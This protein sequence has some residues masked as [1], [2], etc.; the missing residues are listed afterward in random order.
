MKF[1][2]SII[3]RMEEKQINIVGKN[4]KNKLKLE[5]VIR[6]YVKTS[7]IVLP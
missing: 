6:Y 2:I 1:I 3:N 4:A 5:R 7:V